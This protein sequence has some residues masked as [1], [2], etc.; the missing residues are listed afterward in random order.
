MNLQ[1]GVR[2]RAR[3]VSSNLTAGI[4]AALRPLT[5]DFLV[6]GDSLKLSLTKRRADSGLV[7]LCILLTCYDTTTDAL[8]V[9][10]MA[11]NEARMTGL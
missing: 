1:T 8:N 11:P 6:E 4:P 2:C 5:G 9:T 7:M 10:P 3:K